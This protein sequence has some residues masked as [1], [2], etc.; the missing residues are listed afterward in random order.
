MVSG[1]I[2]ATSLDGPH[3]EEK[4]RHA[5]TASVAQA[6]IACGGEARPVSLQRRNAAT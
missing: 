5:V 3:N 2:L 1:D 4:G 6:D